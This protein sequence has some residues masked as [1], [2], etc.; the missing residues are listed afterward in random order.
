MAEDGFLTTGV[1]V[2]ERH[3]WINVTT[4]PGMSVD[5]FQASERK[6]EM[7]FARKP[8]KRRSWAREGRKIDTRWE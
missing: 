1:D 6:K 4:L 8:S 5:R 7:R 3:T 2:G